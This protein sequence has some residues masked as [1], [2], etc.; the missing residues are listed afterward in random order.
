M[1]TILNCDK[2]SIDGYIN[3]EKEN[4]DESKYIIT[5]KHT[6]NADKFLKQFLR[7]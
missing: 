7:S 4:S 3:S 6:E 1:S 5:N 2:R